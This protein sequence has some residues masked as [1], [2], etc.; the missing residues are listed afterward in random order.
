VL[1]LVRYARTFSACVTYAVMCFLHSL[2]KIQ[3]PVDISLLAL[4]LYTS[5]EICQPLILTVKAQPLAE[6]HSVGQ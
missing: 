3:C 1:P 4:L 5:L 2:L 6:I